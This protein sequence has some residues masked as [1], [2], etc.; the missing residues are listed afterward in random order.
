MISG[1]LVA[2]LL[3]APGSGR[4]AAHAERCPPGFEPELRRLLTIELKAPVVAAASNGDSNVQVRCVGDRYVVTLSDFSHKPVELEVD[5]SELDPLAVPRAVTL[6]VAEALTSLWRSPGDV[7]VVVEAPPEV[8]VEPPAPVREES[9]FEL[10]L[11]GGGRVSGL[12][13]FGGGVALDVTALSFFGVRVDF[14]ASRGS[15]S[16]VSG[17]VV[18]SL[19][20]G[21]ANVDLRLTRE[22]WMLR[23]GVGFRVGYALLDGLPVNESVVAGHVSGVMWGPQL[24][25]GASWRPLR[26]LAFGLGADGGVWAPRL[27]GEV[28]GE[29][30]VRI[31]G[32]FASLWASAGVRW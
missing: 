23:G 14:A 1:V 11:F 9:K 8:I 10:S 7:A 3:A 32:L 15:A 17:V 19:F 16:R 25:V 30:P 31:D 27:E 5:T 24:S 20:D 22:H 18:A 28:V 21:S 13:L 12:P 6:V 2:L 26:W 4:V 29:A